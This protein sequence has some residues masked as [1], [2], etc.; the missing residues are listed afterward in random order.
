MSRVPHDVAL[1]RTDVM[2][3]LAPYDP[4]VAGTPPLGLDL[5]DSDIDIVCEVRDFDAFATL[6]TEHFGDRPDFAV[7][8][9]PDLDA[10]IVR[11]RAW[12]WPFEIFGQ[13]LPVAQQHGWRHFC[14]ERRLLDLGGPA[15]AQAIMALRHR[16]LKTE[17][18][19]ATL[20]G[21]TG[22][23]YAALLE[24]E[25]QDDAALRALLP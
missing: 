21:L 3:L 19:F 7:H 22:N 10:M 8:A 16:G 13:A 15:L 6:L 25:G 24:L 2:A 5:T 12:D 14:V 4:H 1:Q 18:A 23:P 9:R 17:P 11:F 20:L